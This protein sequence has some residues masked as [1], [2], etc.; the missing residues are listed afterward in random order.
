VLS[1]AHATIA[2]QFHDVT[3][4]LEVANT[5]IC[6][7]VVCL[8]TVERNMVRFEGET[9]SRPWILRSTMLFRREAGTWTMLHRHV[10]PLIIRQDLAAIRKL[11]P[12]VP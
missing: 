5:I 12:D 6:D 9:G 10:D 11:L 8:V 4:D 2:S 3:T 1:E 7:D